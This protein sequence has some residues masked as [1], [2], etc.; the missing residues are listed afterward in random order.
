MKNGNKIRK[1]KSKNR[2]YIRKKKFFDLLKVYR[3]DIKIARVKVKQAFGVIYLS[4]S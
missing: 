1:K 3:V 2:F 4:D